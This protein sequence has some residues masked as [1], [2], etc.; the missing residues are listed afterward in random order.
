MG[1]MAKKV[2]K[3]KE[4]RKPTQFQEQQAQAV[5]RNLGPG[6]VA[7]P[8]SKSNPML[9]ISAGLVTCAFLFVYYHVL[10]LNQMEDLSNGL[11]M[12]DQRIFGYT[13][14][15]VQ[16]LRGQM[17]S[18]AAGQLNYLHKTAGLLFPLLTGIFSMLVFI[19][20]IPNRKTRLIAWCAPLL[21][22]VT[23]I[24][25]NFLID[26][27]FTGDLG[28]GTVAVASILTTIRWVTLIITA[29]LIIGLGLTR[30]NKALRRK[31]VE[32]REQT[33]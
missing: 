2:K 25:E 33:S 7:R 4:Y 21:F 12:P 8:E 17:N 6:T 9:L 15:D 27:L 1:G 23:D 31:M 13:F 32:I 20:W 19:R 11:S 29:G 26:S 24:V 30:A 28:A 10:T 18:D 16:A 3:S 14:G 22:A 5:V